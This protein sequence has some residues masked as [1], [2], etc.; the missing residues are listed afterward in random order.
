MQKFYLDVISDNVAA[1]RTYEKNGLIEEVQGLLDSGVSETQLIAFGLEYKWVTQY[2]IQSISF[3]TMRASLFKAICQY[4]KR[5]RSWFRRM[6]R[7]GT[8]I[9][10]IP[11]G[12]GIPAFFDHLRN[13]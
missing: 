13:R 9:H 11:G 4:S 2:A 7:L 6:E 5:Q 3:K 10:W 8:A 1:I 12:Q